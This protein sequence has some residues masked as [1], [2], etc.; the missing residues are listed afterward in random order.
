MTRVLLGYHRQH[1]QKMQKHPTERVCV[2]KTCESPLTWIC[3]YKCAKTYWSR[4]CVCSVQKAGWIHVC[5]SAVCWIL[6]SLRPHRAP[7]IEGSET[8]LPRCF[9]SSFPHCNSN[10]SIPLKYP[11]AVAT[12]PELRSNGGQDSKSNVLGPAGVWIR[13]HRKTK[14]LAIPLYSPE[15]AIL[16]PKLTGFWS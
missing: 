11:S 12:R 8:E 13:C 1:S 15:P 6:D 2:Y 7:Y 16:A 14:P 4:A 9:Q 3:V 5:V 10:C